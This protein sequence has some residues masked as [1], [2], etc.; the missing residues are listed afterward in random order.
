M[1]AQFTFNERAVRSLAALVNGFRNQFLASSCFPVD[2]HRGVGRGHHG[3]HA[4]YAP[5]SGA[6]A[7][8]AR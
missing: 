7:D 4:E 6:V 8:N 5:Q 1:A 2:Q 3:H